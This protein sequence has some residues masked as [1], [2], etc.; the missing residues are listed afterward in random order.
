M[1]DKLV[2]QNLDAILTSI[3]C[4]KVEFDDQEFKDFLYINAANALYDADPVYRK[5]IDRHVKD[6]AIRM[7][8]I[9]DER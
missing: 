4:R 9:A 1:T 8:N 7:L 5:K 3:H 2:V 6:A